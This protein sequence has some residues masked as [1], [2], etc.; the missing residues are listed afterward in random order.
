MFTGRNGILSFL[1]LILPSAVVVALI[2][3]R[4]SKC[5]KQITQIELNQWIQGR[6]Q[7]PLPPPLFLG[8]KQFF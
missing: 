1:L 5:L 8:R 7:P 3:V 4:P 2:P 6:G